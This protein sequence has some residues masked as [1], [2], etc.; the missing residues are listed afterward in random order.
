MPCNFQKKT[1]FKSIKSVKI[2]IKV[3]ETLKYKYL[4]IKKY[5]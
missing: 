2:E 4:N 1:D 3:F 5:Q